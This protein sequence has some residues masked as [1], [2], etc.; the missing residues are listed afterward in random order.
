MT[1]IKSNC[2]IIKC[3]K[4]PQISLNKPAKTFK[5]KKVNNLRLVK[6]LNY[7]CILQE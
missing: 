4:K 7:D 3:E 1:A 5:K 2:K 6:T